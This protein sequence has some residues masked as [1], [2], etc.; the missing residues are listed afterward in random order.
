MIAAEVKGLWGDAIQWA[1]YT[2]NRVPH[3]TLGGKAPIELLLNN[4]TEG[5]SRSNLR[6][7][8]QKVMIHI[9]KGQRV[10]RMAPRAVEARLIGYTETHEVYQTIMTT[11]KRQLAKNPQPIRQNNGEEEE[12][13]QWPEESGNS[14]F[15]PE[16]LQTPETTKLP[17]PETPSQQLM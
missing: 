3:K 13:L 17:D 5:N 16:K 2:K 15:K 1:A 14:A 4:K 6:P 8:G 12:E 9:Y 11:G 7:F 10:D